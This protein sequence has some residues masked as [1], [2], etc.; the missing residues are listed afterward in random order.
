M[1]PRGP[2]PLLGH[3]GWRLEGA[4]LGDG[5]NKSGLELHLALSDFFLTSFPSPLIRPAPKALEVVVRALARQENVGE[6]R[7]EVEQDPGGVVVTVHRYRPE[8]AVLGRSD[9]PVG[10]GTYLTVGLPLADD[11][12][13]RN[14]GLVAD[15]D[16]DG[17]PCLLV[18][19]RASQQPGQLQG[20]RCS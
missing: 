14:R 15:V 19:R 5:R 7:V 3:V 12:V 18:D 9:H 20:R 11:E 1:S 6:H 2:A 4:R 16:D 10:D 17:V 13:V 8:L